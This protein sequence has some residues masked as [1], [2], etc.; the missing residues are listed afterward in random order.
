M[1]PSHDQV[2]TVIEQRVAAG[3]DRPDEIDAR[4]A[5]QL[6]VPAEYYFAYLLVS[7]AIER[8]RER[9]L[10]RAGLDGPAAPADAVARAQGL[11]DEIGW[12]AATIYQDT[13]G[14]GH[15]DVHAAAGR[16]I[17]ATLHLRAGLDDLDAEHTRDAG[18]GQ[19]GVGIDGR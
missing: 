10:G 12:Q 3:A 2:L 8:Y 13:A 15:T 5:E 6:G 4:I 16:I 17:A 14:A 1:N 9:E 19:L 7:G 11:A 18:R